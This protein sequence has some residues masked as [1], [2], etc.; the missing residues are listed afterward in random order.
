MKSDDKKRAREMG[1][2]R[3]LRG[4]SG[5]AQAESLLNAQVKNMKQLDGGSWKRFL[6]KTK[7]KKNL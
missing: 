4:Q 7:E 2:K 1:K 5:S 3:K 6:E